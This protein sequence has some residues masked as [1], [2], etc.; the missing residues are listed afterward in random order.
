MSPWPRNCLLSQYKLEWKEQISV[1]EGRKTSP[2]SSEAGRRGF[3]PDK[4]LH[5]VNQASFA[6]CNEFIKHKNILSFPTI[7][8]KHY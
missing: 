7:I 2:V 5:A 6:L 3:L 8:D 4:N 1:L